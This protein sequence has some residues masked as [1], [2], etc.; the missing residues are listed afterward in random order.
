MKSIKKISILP[1]II[2]V[3]VLVFFLLFLLFPNSILAQEGF[4][5]CGGPGQDACE[6]C[7]LA[8]MIIRIITFLLLAFTTLVTIWFVYAG[9]LL[10]TAGGNVTQKD[11]AKKKLV[12]GVIGAVIGFGAAFIVAFVMIVLA[13]GDVTLQSLA[14]NVCTGQAP[15]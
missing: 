9:A 5:Q 7:H 10:A 13:D 3:S 6:F 8:G 12:S 14:G 1:I 11:D 4:V 15:R 2:K